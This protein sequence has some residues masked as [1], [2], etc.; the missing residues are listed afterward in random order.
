MSNLDFLTAGIGSDLDEQTLDRLGFRRVQHMNESPLHSKTAIRL[1]GYAIAD[2]DSTAPA[3]GNTETVSHQGGKSTIMR[4]SP[5]IEVA[6]VGFSPRY[7]IV[8]YPDPADPMRQVFLRTNDYVDPANMP[9]GGGKCRQSIDLF[10]A[11]RKQEGKPELWQLNFRGH[12]VSGA[13]NV[14]AKAKG[15]AN[16]AAADIL[17]RTKTK[18]TVHPFAHWLTLGVAE[19]RLVGKTEKSPVN[20]PV[21]VGQPVPVTAEQYATFVELRRELDEYLKAQPYARESAPALPAPNMRPALSQPERA[22]AMGMAEADANGVVR[23]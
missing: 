14:I 4:T 8:S 21:I 19:G 5:T 23:I 7:Y 16:D 3:I 22:A 17:A 20:D 10:V 6:I 11:L 18:V 15:F 1:G 13:M 9:T 12:V 2:E